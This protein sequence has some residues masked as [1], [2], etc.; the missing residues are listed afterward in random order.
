LP[1]GTTLYFIDRDDQE[2]Y[3]IEA[4]FRF[5]P[6]LSGAF[7]VW[8]NDPSLGAYMVDEVSSVESAFS[9]KEDEE[10]SSI[11]VFEYDEG[12]LIDKTEYFEGRESN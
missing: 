11:L 1:P 3:G 5:Q 9:E 12:S 10:A 2:P 6:Y 4:L 7:R 8:Y